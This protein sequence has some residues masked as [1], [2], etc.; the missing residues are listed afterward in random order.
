AVVLARHL[1]CG[2]V[3]GWA[4]EWAGSPVLV[5]SQDNVMAKSHTRWRGPGEADPGGR[6]S[7]Q[8]PV[9]SSQF[10]ANGQ[11]KRG[12]DELGGSEDFRTMTD[13]YD[14]IIVGGGSAGCVLANRLSARSAN[15]V[16]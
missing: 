10:A 15:R 13:Q 11:V 14:F 2:R 4:D 9:S 12:H 8:D 3:A 6:P 16:L 7:R 5:L 1:S